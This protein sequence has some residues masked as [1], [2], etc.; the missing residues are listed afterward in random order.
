MPTK[1]KH[2]EYAERNEKLGSELEPSY[3]DWSITAYFYS[4]LHWTRA[5]LKSKGYSDS[6]FSNHREAEKSLFDAGFCRLNDYKDLRSLS[7]EMRYQC[8]TDHRAILLINQ[9]K[10]DLQLVKEYVQ[11][12][13]SP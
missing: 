2:T 13:L 9:A 8:P 6:D 10:E 12:T 1:E 7:R 4:A 3:P 5:W 11:G